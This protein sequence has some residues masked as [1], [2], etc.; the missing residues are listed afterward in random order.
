[1]VGVRVSVR[2]RVSVS[3]WVRIRAL[4]DRWCHY[5]ATV[6][7][8]R[9]NTDIVAGTVQ[10]TLVV[11]TLYTRYNT[12][13]VAYIHHT[14]TVQYTLVV[15]ILYI[16]TVHSY[17]GRIHTMVEPYQVSLVHTHTTCSIQMQ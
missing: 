16:S 11:Y 12:D 14:G 10:Y 8:T 7:Y 4:A 6:L 13:I 17:G 1:M 3:G 9:Y 15:Y 2:V 5:S